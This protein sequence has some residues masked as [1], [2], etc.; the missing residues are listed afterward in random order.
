MNNGVAFIEDM[1]AH[2]GARRDEVAA[3]NCRR[4][5]SSTTTFGLERQ[6]VIKNAFGP[7]RTTT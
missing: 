2:T 5:M 4:R 1:R 7:S 6:S 3:Q